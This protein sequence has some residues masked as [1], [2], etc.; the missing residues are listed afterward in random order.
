MDIRTCSRMKSCSKSLRGEARVL[1]PPATT[2]MSA[3]SI[4]CFFRNFRTAVLMRWSKQQST[5]ASATY[6]SAGESKWKILRMEDTR[7]DSNCSGRV[8]I[9]AGL[10]PGWA[11]ECARP[12]VSLAR[13]H[14]L[15]LVLLVTARC[16]L[17][18]PGLLGGLL[19]R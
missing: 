8:P 7:F 10:R 6:W 5:A 11:D 3:R 18:F 14:A 2:I 1:A 13:L 16:G 17:L 15:S 9:V 12:Y 4:P 19:R